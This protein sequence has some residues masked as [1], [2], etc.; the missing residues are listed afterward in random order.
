MTLLRRYSEAQSEEA[1]GTLVARHLNLVYAAALRHVRNPHQAEDIAQTVFIILAKKASRLPKKTVLAGWLYQTTRLAAANFVRT[2]I[3]RSRRDQEV[4]MQRTATEPESTIW[5]S[6][7]PLL[8]SAMGVLSDKDKNAV[9]LRFFQ[10]KSLQQVGVAL[11]ASENAA[12]KRVARALEKLRGFFTKRGVSISAVALASAISA[13]TVEAAPMGLAAS[14]TAG[15]AKGTTL[16]VASVA[17]V[18]AT[19]NTMNWMQFKYAAGIAAFVVLV[20]SVGTV[21]LSTRSAKGLKTN[22]APLAAF[23][24]F[25]GHGK[26]LTLDLSEISN[27]KFT[28]SVLAV[29]DNNGENNLAAFPQGFHHFQGTMFEVRGIVQ[30]SSR[31]LRG[32]HKPYPERITAKSVG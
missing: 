23:Q 11:G 18:K 17:L 28:E 5:E 10:G 8:D 12:K 19:I 29:T 4:F 22:P 31:P 14:I 9:V 1:F 15:A 24:G 25:S 6:I 26:F 2:E 20:G 13:H 32:L 27:A 16:G 7:A 30:L 3:R 21:A